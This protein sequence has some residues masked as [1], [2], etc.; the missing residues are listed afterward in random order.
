MTYAV[1]ALHSDLVGFK[2]RKI[3]VRMRFIRK[4]GTVP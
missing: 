4:D 3:A 1:W 2:V